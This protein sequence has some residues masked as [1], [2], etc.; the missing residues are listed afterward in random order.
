MS[1][2]D[3]TTLEKVVKDFNLEVLDKDLHSEAKSETL[4]G[5]YVTDTMQRVTLAKN[6]NTEKA[7][8][9]LIIAP[10]IYYVKKKVKQMSF[11]SGNEFNVDSAKGLN[12]FCDYIIT[13]SKQQHFI[14]HPIAAMV[15]AKKGNLVDAYGQCAS[16]MVAA[17]IFNLEKEDAIEGNRK[18]HGIVTDGE[19]WDF[20]SLQDKKLE[21]N[22]KTYHID[23]VAKIIGIIRS[24]VQTGS[25][26]E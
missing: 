19:S 10:I 9:E 5:E 26:S 11:F 14:D 15:E 16:E 18:I 4:P 25:H 8:S 21:I 3:F 22:K 1:Y 12:G 6:I 2:K 13:A 24:I 7:R 17:Q 23:N 20:L